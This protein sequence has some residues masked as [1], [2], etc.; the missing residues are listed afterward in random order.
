MPPSNEG[1]APPAHWPAWLHALWGTPVQVCWQLG[2]SAARPVLS[3][4]DA[5]AVLHLPPEW[6]QSTALAACAHAAA[7]WRFGG[8]PQPRTGLKPVQQALFA[9]LEDARVEWLALRELPGLRALWR[10]FHAGEDARAGNGFEDLLARLARDLLEDRPGD[11]HPW[12]HKARTL[13]FQADGRTLAL[14]SPEQVRAA[15][16]RLGNDIGQMRLPFN[17]A[18]YRPHAAYRDDGSWLW[19]PEAAAPD[20]DTTLAAQAD[21]PP[22]GQAQAVRELPDATPLPYP[23]WDTR[24]GRYRRDWCLVHTRVAQTGDAAC[25]LVPDGAR[26]RRLVHALARLRGPLPQHAGRAALGQDFHAAALLDACVQRRAGRTPDD[27]VYRQRVWPSRGLAVQV[28]LDA[29][30]STAEEG[31]EGGTVLRGMAAAALDTVWALEALGH[32]AALCAFRSRGRTRVDVE[33]LKHWHEPAAAP[34]VRAR[35]GAQESAGST[36]MGAAL[37]HAAG[38]AAAFARAHRAPHP[39][40]LLLTDG[41][42]HDVDVPD[43]AYL[44]G[45]LRRAVAEAEAGGVAVRG[46]HFASGA[47]GDALAR[48]LGGRVARVRTAAALP[49]VLMPLLAR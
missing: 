10:P 24:I 18:T 35:C 21:A 2:G 48:A 38:Q 20:S 46:L 11:P 4:R 27:R 39:L 36:R 3:G 25:A 14:G 16:S 33:V 37:R 12:V 22:G 9:V 29:S 19:Q 47:A 7:H 43:P 1:A 8:P 32:H 28:L 42:A 5:D 30:A 40:V 49:R 15:A 26:G 45:D 34:Q 23:E 41:D 31:P 13:F 44:L 17:A 6:P